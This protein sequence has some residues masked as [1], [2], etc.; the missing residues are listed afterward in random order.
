[1]GGALS[2]L[3]TRGRCLLAGGI[4]AALCSLILDERDLLRIAAFVVALPLL[5]SV[6]AGRARVGLTAAREML[7]PRVPVGSSAQVQLTV[8]TSG[9]L[10]S[11]GLL[12]E[13]NVPYALG[14]R[15]R[16]VVEHIPRHAGATL[17]YPLQPVMRGVHR[18]GPL[19]AKVTDP[20]GLAEFERELGGQHRFV[21][22]PKVAGLRGMPYGS[23]IGAGEE[24]SVRLRAG[25]GEDDAIV[26]PYRTGDDMRKVH[27]KSTA[28]RDELVVRVEERPA[29]GG[30]TVLLDHR[31][32]AHRGTGPTASLEWAVSFAGSACLHLHHCGQPVRLVT[33]DG[34]SVLSSASGSAGFLA[35]RSVAGLGTPLSGQSG[36]VAILDALAGLPIS[37]QHHLGCGRDPAAGQE[38]LA[39][40]GSVGSDAIGE[41]LRYRARRTRS[42]AVLLDVAAWGAGSGEPAVDP[43]E[44]AR[45][46]RGAGW[47]VVIAGPDDGFQDVWHALCRA[48]TP[49][50]DLTGAQP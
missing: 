5:A 27:W 10:P 40:L 49:R 14:S 23:G 29:R 6:L 50:S 18:V 11:G 17:S 30:S 38:L 37:H 46:L 41:L 39:V 13:D 34:R 7:P 2:G 4:A 20:F 44:S 9:R 12:L 26:R 47:N 19:R 33:A 25:Q 42:M 21:V 28:R 36:D 15:A 16:F 8:H 22:V 3:T 35:D 43:A 48:T 24:G 45:L 1:M 32:P 31:A